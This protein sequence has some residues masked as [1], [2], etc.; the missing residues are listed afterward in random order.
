MIRVLEKEV[1]LLLLSILCLVF[2]SAAQKSR[3]PYKSQLTIVSENDN[4]TFKY[5]DRYYTNGLAIRFA[6]AIGKPS[7]T[8]IK[9]VLATEVGQMIFVPYQANRSYR[10]TMD[11]PFTGLLYAKGGLSYFTPKNNV[12]RWSA[13]AGVIGDA[14]KGKEVQ[15][16]HHQNFNL[17]YPYGWE[18]QLRS[19]FGANLQLI[20]YQHLFRPLGNNV[21]NVHA[22]AEV[23]AGSFFTQ[24]SSGLVLKLGAFEKAGQSAFWEGG[25][26]GRSGTT[27]RNHELF[28]YFEPVV[29]YQVYNATV[30]GGMF[31]RDEN[32]YT[33]TIQP[34]YYT[35]KYGFMFAQGG[36]SLQ[37]GFTFK[38]KEARTMKINENYG[39]IGL[40]FRL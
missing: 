21:F 19:E 12:L 2:N 23:Q 40:G 31:T 16:W 22:K 30:Q 17:P 5:R 10:T 26:D 14:A 9:K 1:L 4:Y 13:L 39:T 34:Y 18:T 20:Y 15:R 7:S 38:T 25:F 36:F 6:K 3:R 11:R 35:H 37:L 33:T 28:I 27:K 8:G 32:V 29:T 24:L